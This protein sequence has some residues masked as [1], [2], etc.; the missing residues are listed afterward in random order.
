MENNYNGDGVDSRDLRVFEGIID[1]IR[2]LLESQG[3]GVQEV[4]RI[5]PRKSR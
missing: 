5:A 2:L 3:K 1:R 4:S